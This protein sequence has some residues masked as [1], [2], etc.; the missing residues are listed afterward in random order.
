MCPEYVDCC[1]CFKNS[2]HLISV[3]DICCKHPGLSKNLLQIEGR[4]LTFMQHH[5]WVLGTFVYYVISFLK[6]SAGV[7][8]IVHIIQITQWSLGRLS[9]SLKTTDQKFW[10]WL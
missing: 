9:D 1:I 2:Y 3:D 7:G 10:R 5:L 4:K 6:Y 8:N